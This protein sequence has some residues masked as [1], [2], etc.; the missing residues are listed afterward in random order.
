MMTSVPPHPSNY[1]QRAGRSGRND[2]PRSACITLCAS[3]SVG[4][5]T[6]LNPMECL[7]NRPMQAPFV[8]L[9]SPQVIQRHANAY[10]FRLSKI[11]FNNA[12]GNSNN[13]DQEVIEFF[14]PF[15]F[16][17]DF[18][19]IRYDQVCDLNGNLKYPCDKLGDKK[20]TKYYDFR[21]FLDNCTTDSYYHLD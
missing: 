21:C 4:L 3:D 12:R 9:K 1:K 2:N 13:L 18:D 6:I 8:D 7:I 17:K 19:G 14:T 15:S 11:F 16:G 20:T 10:L 5:R